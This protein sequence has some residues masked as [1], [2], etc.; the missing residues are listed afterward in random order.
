MPLLVSPIDNQTPMQQIRRDGIE[1]DRCPI[2]GGVWLD[3]GEL[4]KL[5]LAVQNAAA[6]DR[7]EFA[8]FQSQRG[9]MNHGSQAPRHHSYDDDDYEDYHQK[10]H[11]KQSKLKTLFNLFD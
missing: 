10:K 9:P 6:E 1:I 7:T 3:K 4:E 5:L 2:S 11:G 8:E